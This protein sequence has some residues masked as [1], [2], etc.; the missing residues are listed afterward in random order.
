MRR[1]IAYG[2]EDGI[3]LEGLIG[4]LPVLLAHAN[5]TIALYLPAHPW[6]FP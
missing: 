6:R 1:R 2:N 3:V 4:I 5:A